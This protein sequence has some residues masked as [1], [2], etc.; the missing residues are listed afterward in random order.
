MKIYNRND[1]AVKVLIVLINTLNTV[2]LKQK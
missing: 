1:I 2:L